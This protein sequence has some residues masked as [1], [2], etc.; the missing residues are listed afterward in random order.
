[1]LQ[2]G[3][4]ELTQFRNPRARLRRALARL[5][6]TLRVR[7]GRSLYAVGGWTWCRE[8]FAT[9][10]PPPILRT[11]RQSLEIREQQDLQA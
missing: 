1:M 3:L 7:V 6:Q 8:G 4:E 10:H 5:P 11:L 9:D 2:S